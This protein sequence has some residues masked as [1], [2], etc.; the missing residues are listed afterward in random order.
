[1]S[2]PPVTVAVAHLL[3]DALPVDAASEVRDSTDV[4][5]LIEAARAGDRDAFGELVTLNERAILRAAVA[6]LG[7]RSEA[8]E[9]AQEACLV[10]WRKLRGFRGDSSFRTWLLTIVWRKSLDRRRRRRKWLSRTL[11]IEKTRSETAVDV[12]VS[13]DADPER[14]VVSRD[15]ADRAREAIQALSP[16]LRDVLL[17]AAGGEHSYAEIAAMLRIPLGTVKWRVSEARKIVGSKLQ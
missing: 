12:L 6:A 14:V 11:D 5:A 1:M 15:L 10:A 17:L 3:R 7:D 4:L 13:T 16:K 9:A 2:T 8:E